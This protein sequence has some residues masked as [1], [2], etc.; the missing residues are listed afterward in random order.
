M[1]LYSTVNI[2][3]TALLGVIHNDPVERTSAASFKFVGAYLA[4][5]IVSATALPFAKYFGH[6]SEGKGWQTTMIIYGITAVIFFLITFLSTK[7][8]IQP[9]AKEKTSIKND[10]KDLLKNQP[11][12]ILFIVTILFILFWS[13]RLGVTAHYFKYYVREQEFS[14]FGNTY[15]YGFE[16]FA[17]AFN[18]IGQACSLIGVLLVPWFS[19][20]FGTKKST[21]L[22]FVGS[23][24]F[25]GAF[26]FFR[27]EDLWWIFSFQ[28]LGSLVGGPVS[29]LLWVM[30]A[31]TADHSEWKTGRR[32]TG[33]V[34]SAS[35]MSNKMG[36]AIGS[37]V[38]GLILAST[39]FVAN[40]AQNV[41]VLYGLKAMMS[42]IPLGAGIIALILLIFFYKLDE[43]VMKKVKADL[44]D[45]RK[46]IGVAAQ[47]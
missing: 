47:A 36:W 37:M 19:K 9:I 46:V 41:N 44:E 17:S 11:W 29:T 13:I 3:Y 39:G 12:I 27:P 6:G 8:R 20:I 42:I 10:L 26:I 23:M 24:I 1:F 25:T 21:I 2:P 34:F 15:K 40:I 4:G 38:A 45:R 7:E 35:I 32:A 5:F 28:A 30:Y 43:P 18:T 16:V 22:L 33:L 31:D 14:F